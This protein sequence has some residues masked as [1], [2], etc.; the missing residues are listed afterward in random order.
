MSGAFITV[1]G[2]E[3]V[4]KSSS[5]A[6]VQATLTAAGL[7]TV[8]TREPG[9]TALGEQVREWILHGE[10]GALSAHVEALLMFAARAQHLDELIG[11]ALRRGEWVICDRF[12]DATVAY[13]GGGRGA[14]RKLLEHLIEGVQGSIAPDLTLL[15]DAPV[16]VGLARI[17][18]RAHDHFEREDRAFFERVRARYLEIAADEPARVKVIDASKTPEIVHAQ[19]TR[20]VTAFV[21][22][23]RSR[24]G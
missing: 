22:S 13:Q 6:A 20:A 18:D 3:G 5:L 19:I 2:T 16:D 23:Y 15:L 11:P 9:G 21:E 1:E 10:H 4:G 7:R 17:N 24:H 8:T 14:D 12:S